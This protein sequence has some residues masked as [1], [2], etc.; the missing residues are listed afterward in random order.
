MACYNNNIINM[1]N[2]MSVQDQKHYA[3]F[4]QGVKSFKPWMDNA[5][6]VSK[7]PLVKPETLDDAMKLL[8]EV[9]VKD[10]LALCKCGRADMRE[11]TEFAL[12][13]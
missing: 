3:E 12:L 2:V 6:T 11:C 7:T 9:K 8:G 13:T 1:L 5:D 4:F 10:R